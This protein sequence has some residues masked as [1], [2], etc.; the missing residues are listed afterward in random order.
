MYSVRDDGALAPTGFPIRTFSDHRSFAAS[1]DLSQRT[2]SFIAS[3][4]QGIHREPFVASHKTS[5]YPLPS[6]CLRR[7]TRSEHCPAGTHRSVLAHNRS[8]APESPPNARLRCDT[9][10]PSR[11]CVMSD[12]RDVRSIRLE[13]VPTAFARGELAVCRTLDFVVVRIVFSAGSSRRMSPTKI[14][15]APTWCS[16]KERPP[17][18]TRLP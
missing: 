9:R 11:V 13:C 15:F 1:R 10:P 3:W 4:R 14:L 12:V 7:V 16:R 17:R 2:T 5:T 8:R 18:S 6:R